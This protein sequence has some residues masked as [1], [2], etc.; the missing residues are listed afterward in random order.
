MTGT[1]GS[2]RKV[3]VDTFRDDPMFPRVERVVAELL[4]KGN[5]VA[6]VDVIIGLGLLRREHLDD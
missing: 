3:A 5:V 2:T 4:H 6:P 1:R